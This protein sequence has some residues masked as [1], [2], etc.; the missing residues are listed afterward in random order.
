MPR[1]LTFLKSAH[2][3]QVVGDYDGVMEH[4]MS[5]YGAR[6]EEDFRG[7]LGPYDVCLLLLGGAA[8][9]ELFYSSHPDN[10]FARM[11]NR[12]GNLWHAIQFIVP[13]IEEAVDILHERGI[14]ATDVN[15][16]IRYSFADPRDTFGLR[17]QMGDREW[18]VVVPDSPCG[19]V[20]LAGLTVA[21]RD[22]EV[23]A[24]FFLDL[25]AGAKPLYRADRAAL[26]AS[27]VAIDVCGYNIEFLSPI[28]PGEIQDSLD[29]FDQHIRS[30]TFR[31]ESFGPLR[32]RFEA[33][34]IAL[35]EG[36]QPQTLA[37]RNTDNF[38][39]PLQFTE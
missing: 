34:G 11:H 10:I 12:F 18:P 37:I 1:Q 27:G 16:E 19:I 13:S 6:L 17:L 21:V 32:E 39:V 23:A 9:L 3:N 29:R 30:A 15:L 35:V 22:A 4:Y 20:D 5:V 14:R 36:D 31:V 2:I 24:S 8:R 33:H 26:S 7:E 38:G 28:G 25:V